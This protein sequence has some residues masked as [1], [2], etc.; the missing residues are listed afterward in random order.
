MTTIGDKK[1]FGI[2]IDVL[3]NTYGFAKIWFNNNF[4]GN[5]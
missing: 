4:F 2:E 3:N 1:K 5:N